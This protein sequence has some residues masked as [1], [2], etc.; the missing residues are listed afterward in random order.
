MTNR[1]MSTRMAAVSTT[2]T[3]NVDRIF[4]RP[5]PL[6]R[7]EE[8]AVD[9]TETDEVDEILVETENIR[10][11]YAASQRMIELVLHVFQETT[12][13]RRIDAMIEARAVCL[14]ESTN[15]EATEAEKPPV[16]E[17]VQNVVRPVVVRVTVNE[18]IQRR[19]DNLSESKGFFRKPI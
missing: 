3:W 19:V 14:L 16:H 15:R 6:S 18:V 7:K 8:D 12:L 9:L 17:A 5:G 13:C 4:S 2:D 11:T 10:P 1:Q